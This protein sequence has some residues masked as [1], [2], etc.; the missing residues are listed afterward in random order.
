MFYTSMSVCSTK[1]LQDG[2]VLFLK[3][4]LC[5]SRGA[6]ATR[7]AIVET[8]HS[9]DSVIR[10][11]WWC[12]NPYVPNLSNTPRLS[13]LRPGRLSRQR[14]G[15]HCAPMCTAMACRVEKPLRPETL[16]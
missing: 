8:G 7:G 13:A 16:A 11:I 6:Q 5:S 10:G 15:T 1:A 14:R 9:I 4:A 3:V 2:S 12:R